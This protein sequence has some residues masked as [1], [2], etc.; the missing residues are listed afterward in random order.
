MNFF[1]V[2][3]VG[4]CYKWLKLVPI[5]FFGAGAGASKKKKIDR[6]RN[7]GEDAILKYCI[8]W[9]CCGAVPFCPGSGSS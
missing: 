4:C 7:T 6:L 5:L 1:L 9:Q 8:R 3:R 2:R